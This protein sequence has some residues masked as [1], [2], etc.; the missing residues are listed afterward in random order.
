MSLHA[1]NPAT[2]ETVATY[3]E[4]SAEAVRGVIADVH[5]AHLAWRNTRFSERAALMRNAAGVLRADAREYARLMAEEMGKPIRD[6]IAEAQKPTRALS[7]ST[8]SASC[9]R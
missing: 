4:M 7:R 3:E 5:Q 2:G 8:R 9:W 6:G 1:I